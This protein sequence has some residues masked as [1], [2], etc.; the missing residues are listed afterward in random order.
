MHILVCC[1]STTVQFHSLGLCCWSCCCIT[2]NCIWVLPLGGRIGCPVAL[3]GYSG[4]PSKAGGKPWSCAM[5]TCDGN[6]PS[7]NKDVHQCIKMRHCQF[8]IHFHF[9]YRSIYL[10][11][12]R[13]T[14]LHKSRPKLLGLNALCQHS[15]NHIRMQVRRWTHHRHVR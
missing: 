5:S 10:Q 7:V 3:R 4:C 13:L 6:I 11:K 14:C 12:I 15:L 2:A 9:I 8:Y 1:L